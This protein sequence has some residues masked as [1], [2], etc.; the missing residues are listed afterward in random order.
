KAAVSEPSRRPAL[1][2]QSVEYLQ[3]AGDRYELARALFDLVEAYESLG[4]FRRARTVAGRAQAAALECGAEPMISALSR[5]SD[6]EGAPTPL[7]G[8]LIGV[9][10]VGERRVAALA[11]AG[12]SN[13]EIAAKLYITIST[14]EQHLTRT[15]RKL[16]IRRRADLPLVVEFDDQ[17]QP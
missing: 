6:A 9:L 13:R 1:L 7:P 2:R 8:D 14:V 3:L 12:Y 10:S 4:E 17:S 16:N 5:A 11:A 15:Y